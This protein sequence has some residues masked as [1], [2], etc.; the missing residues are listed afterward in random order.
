MNQEYNKQLEDIVLEKRKQWLDNIK[1]LTPLLRSEPHHMTD[2][3]ALALSYRA[4]LLDE[5]GYFYNLFSTHDKTIKELKRDKFI[6]YATGMLPDGTRPKTA[7]HPLLGRK[8]SKTEYDTVI[9]GDLREQEQTLQIIN[10]MVDFV[11]ENIKTID[12]LLYAVKNRIELFN[13]LNK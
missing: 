12:Q 3:Q 1:S 7:P 13:F 8:M 6:Y 10:D 11:R 4:I 2:A 9:S 5:L